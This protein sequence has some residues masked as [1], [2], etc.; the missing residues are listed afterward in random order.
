MALESHFTAG[1]VITVEVVRLE[2]GWRITRL[3]NRV[4]WRTGSGFA[5]MLATGRV[6]S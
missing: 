5:Q 2:R 1:G 4:V 3:E 6:R